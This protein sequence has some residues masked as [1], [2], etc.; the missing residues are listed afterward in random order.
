MKHHPSSAGLLAV[1]GAVL[2]ISV[3]HFA[4]KVVAA[5]GGLMVFVSLW[6]C[7]NMPCY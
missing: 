6:R 7:S 1:S 2:W 4:V 5:L 3:K